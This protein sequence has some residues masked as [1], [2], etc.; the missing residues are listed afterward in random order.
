[1]VGFLVLPAQQENEVQQL[2]LGSRQLVVECEQQ[3]LVL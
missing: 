2:E 3:G 1:M